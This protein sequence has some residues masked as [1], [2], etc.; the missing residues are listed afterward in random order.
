MPI[1]HDLHREI[2]R[3]PAHNAITLCANSRA[4]PWTED[5]LRC[6][7]AKPRNKLE[8]AGG[9]AAGLTI[10]GL[11]HTVASELAEHDVSER[12]IASWLG[13]KTSSAATLLGAEYPGRSPAGA[14]GASRGHGGKTLYLVVPA[15]ISPEAAAFLSFIATPA[16]QSLLREAEI[17]AGVK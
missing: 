14:C 5:G 11:R 1:S 7:C 9:V 17:V 16:G 6:V 15:Q 12:G 2:M 3:A 8:R 13:E 4:Q 10:H